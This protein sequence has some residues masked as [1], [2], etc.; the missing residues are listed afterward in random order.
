MLGS[1]WG[2]GQVFWSFL[3]FTMFFIWIW[4]L[5][6]VFSDIFRSHDLGGV[7]K[8]AWVIFV[9]VLPYL[10]VFVYLIARGHKM[11]EHAAQ[12]AKAIDE[13]QRAYIRD[14]AG[15]SASPAEELTRLADLKAKGVIDDAEFARLKAQALGS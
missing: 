9:V 11:S 15:T 3:W 6:A 2:V 1:E 5:I 14:A 12:N 4:L 7:A 10:G 13:A 8:F